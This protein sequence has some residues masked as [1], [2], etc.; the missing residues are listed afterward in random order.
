MTQGILITPDFT[1]RAVA[2][3]LSELR[4]AEATP[5]YLDE[6]T[7]FV[8]YPVEDAGAP[9]PAASMARNQ[10]STG[11]P[12]FF[13]DPTKALVGDVV[14]VRADGSDV[15]EENLDAAGEIVRAAQAYSEDYPE[16][17]ALWKAAAGNI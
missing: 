9:N 2:V 15:T 1:F 6:S 17:Y 13:A 8:A 12:A 4:E 3:E 16:E 5:V 7:P 14:C 10:Q 11:N